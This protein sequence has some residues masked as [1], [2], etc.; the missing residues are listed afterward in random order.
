MGIIT[1]IRPK[2]WIKNIFIFIP[3]F[4]AGTILSFENLFLLILTFFAFSFVASSIYILNDYKDI[5]S[6]K[7]HPK[8]KFRP[9]ASGKV[10]KRNALMLFFILLI[11]STALMYS[12]R[13]HVLS[14]IYAYFILNI[15]Y[16]LVLKR[17][18]IVDIVCISV[19]FVLR[20]FAGA[21]AV[22]VPVSEWLIL[23]VFLIS[24]LMGF[25]KRR[26]DLL[27]K[28]ESGITLRK[29]IDG[30]TKPFIDLSVTMMAGVVIVCY[31]M[32]VTHES[33]ISRI[34][35]SYLYLTSIFV[36]IGILR[37]LQ[38]TFVE[39]KVKLFEIVSL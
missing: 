30:Y 20:V 35:N 6:D 2:H 33:V 18:A 19:G 29:S 36:I 32:Y 25:A 14:I 10:S 8:K 13:I 37:Y 3:A 26:D 24:L 11:A 34:G 15:F 31:I 28:E 12:T 27:I 17:I 21:F 22:D 39:E 16:T 7:K 5:E 23:M 9:L 38:I 1:L 4:F